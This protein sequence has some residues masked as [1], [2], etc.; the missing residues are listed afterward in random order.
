MGAGL[1][2]LRSRLMIRLFRVFIPT[3][4]VALLITETL[5]MVAAFAGA[6]YIVLNV[7][8]T[9]YLLYDGGLIRVLLAVGTIIAGLHFQ[10]LY[11]EIRVKSRI[12][13]AQQICMAVGVA[14][15]LQGFI[16]YLDADLAVPPP[17]M[18]LGGALCIVATYLWRLLFSATVLQVV[19][20]TRLVLVG[21][22]PLLREIAE[23]AGKHP[24]MGLEIIQYTG[25]PGGLDE[26]IEANYRAHI[27][28]EMSDD[29]DPL[30]AKKLLELRFAGHVIEEA[31]GVYERTHGRIC[32]GKIRWSQ[33]LY[34]G[35]F[36]SQRRSMPYRRVF[37]L[38]AAAAGLVLFSP[39]MLLAAVMVRLSSPGP[40]LH[41]QTCVGRNEA[42][43]TLYRFRSM[44]EHSGAGMGNGGEEDPPM[45]RTGRFLR[46]FGI[47]G[48]PQLFNVLKG[49]MSIVGPHPEGPEFVST[50][51][52]S[53]PYYHQRHSVRPGM[54]GWA[55][56]NGP[57]AE[58]VEDT[59]KSLEYDLYYIKNMSSSLDTYILFSTIKVILLS[60]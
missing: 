36:G 10:D 31:N 57:Y 43:F 53:I 52:E 1:G 16:T 3:G 6:A 38:A 60:R 48:L 9:V 22:S 37:N 59:I 26:I 55:Q 47:D 29:G 56:I 23:H 54:T 4:A 45:T 30:S 28:V 35:A 11:S 58:T 50:L 5:V 18:A 2:D 44:R 12:V 24:E 17:M 40:I 8:P 34:S 21:D 46:R 14:F 13:L 42:P 33:L 49:D 32:L 15:L 41:R 20:S 25:Q 7:D 27:V 51:S 39:M 19:G